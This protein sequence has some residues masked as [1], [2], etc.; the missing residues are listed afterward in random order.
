MESGRS[1]M[2]RPCESC[3]AG[4]GGEVAGIL[5]AGIVI[6]ARC[7]LSAGVLPEGAFV[8]PMKAQLGELRGDLPRLLLRERNP[9]PTAD[10]LGLVEEPGGL[11]LQEGKDLLGAQPAMGAALAPIDWRQGRLRLGVLLRLMIGTAREPAAR[12]LA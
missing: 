5:L 4:V 2:E 9:D 7:G 11:L 8:V 6:G 12:M 1:G 10:D 3:G